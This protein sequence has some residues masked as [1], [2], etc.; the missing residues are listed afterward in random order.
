MTPV[1]LATSR[2]GRGSGLGA[3]L[4]AA[5]GLAALIAWQGVVRPAETALE[6]ARQARSDRHDPTLVR[7]VEPGAPPGGIRT[8]LPMHHVLALASAP[9]GTLVVGHP[10]GSYRLDPVRLTRHPLP[11]APGSPAR[12]VRAVALDGSRVV[13]GH[14]AGGL[15]GVDEGGAWYLIPEAAGPGRVR[16]L[17]IGR[18]RTW[19]GTATDGL[20]WFEP[21]GGRG[22]VSLPV[23]GPV[24]ALAERAGM[25]AV[26]LD[27]IVVIERGDGREVVAV[28]GAAVSCLAWEGD[29]LWIG[30]SDG[31]LVRDRDE[32]APVF[33]R[34]GVTALVAGDGEI[35]A[36]TQGGTVL[37]VRSMPG[38]TFSVEEAGRLPGAV[39]A[40]A[41]SGDGRIYA[42]GPGG[43]HELGVDGRSRV[44][45]AAEAPADAHVSALAADPDGS[46]W[47][48][49][50][51]SGLERISLAGAS[52]E[53]ILEDDLWQ[54]N[55]LL[56][57]DPLRSTAPGLVVATSRGVLTRDRDGSFR[58]IGL[59]EAPGGS[60]ASP[61]YASVLGIPGGLAVAGRDGVT[62]RR[63]SRIEAWSA[64]HGL[65][66]NKAY[67][68]ER[69]G[70]S[71][72]V[73][74]LGGLAEIRGG[75]VAR[76]FRAGASSLPVG[77]VNA[78]GRASGGLFVGTYGGG[79]VLLPAGSDRFL[80][81]PGSPREVNPNALLVRGDRVYTGG[82]DGLTVH[83]GSGRP[84]GRILEGLPSHDVQALAEHPEGLL[85]GCVSGLVLLP[86]SYL[87]GRT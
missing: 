71:L 25:L 86:W 3:G 36:G 62:V 33:G 52:L 85:V 53:R 5:A 70:E 55:R 66:S 21:G 12:S 1:S 19:V 14:E 73:G 82:L 6:A 13:L 84:L 27:G 49:Y 81:V 9:D 79:L 40:L 54:V 47:I 50:F 31:L 30:G 45:V 28:P 7:R 64:F 38:G 74:S 60:V 48:G 11:A 20:W 32:P 61:R 44:L 39:K 69:D 46:V 80:P 18:G 10:G 58:R 41:Q 17:A 83:D 42:G 16:A 65:P 59:G 24:L 43:L 51:H 37:R 63:E 26:G 87:E 4:L 68:L 77:W 29:R 56:A 2:P 23:G 34:D 35:L 78:L 57:P 76:S 72:W 22:E 15:A 8:F 67:C 75:R